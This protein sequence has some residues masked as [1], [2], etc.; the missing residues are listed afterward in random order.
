[1]NLGIVVILSSGQRSFTLFKQTLSAK[2]IIDEKMFLRIKPAFFRL[3]Q[4]IN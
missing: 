1:M 2:Y 3:L 4:S